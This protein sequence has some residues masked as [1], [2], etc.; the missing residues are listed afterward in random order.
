M[1]FWLS[2]LLV[3]VAF[4]TGRATGANVAH[5][6]MAPY[7][8]SRL[9]WL[10]LQ[11]EIAVKEDTVNATTGS[12]VTVDTVGRV[13]ESIVLRVRYMPNERRDEMNKM[14]ENKKQLI[15]AVAKG[16]RW[17][18]WLKIDEDVAPLMSDQ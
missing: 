15:H 1:K 4:V 5:P 13:P 16:Y 8:P 17:D 12:G 9:E 7:T 3:L 10:E 14:I 18:S 11:C 2:A 6:G